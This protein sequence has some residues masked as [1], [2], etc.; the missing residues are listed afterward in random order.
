[1]AHPEFNLEDHMMVNFFT[2]TRLG[3]L[4]CS[5]CFLRS[6]PMLFLG[7]IGVAISIG[8]LDKFI[9]GFSTKVHESTRML[10]MIVEKI[11]TYQL[12]FGLVYN[13]K[14]HTK[15]ENMGLPCMI[16]VTMFILDFV[17]AWFSVYSC[18]LAGPRTEQVS[19]ALET[20]VLSPYRKSMLG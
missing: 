11:T 14:K 7:F 2:Y 13:I 9:V 1:M 18:Y 4:I 10:M 8:N 19:S 12:L 6:E 20:R 3:I 16:W 15:P 5:W 17:A